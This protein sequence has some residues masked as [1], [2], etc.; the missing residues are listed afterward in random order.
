MS[1]C[2]VLVQLS[3]SSSPNYSSVNYQGSTF[4]EATLA[5]KSTIQFRHVRGHV[6]DLLTPSK[7]KTSQSLYPQGAVAAACECRKMKLKTFL[8]RLASSLSHCK[9]TGTSASPAW[10]ALLNAEVPPSR[11]KNDNCL[12]NA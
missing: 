2:P 5:Q 6:P 9:P 8:D 4:V 12:P 3:P 7:E 11:L 10:L 1:Q